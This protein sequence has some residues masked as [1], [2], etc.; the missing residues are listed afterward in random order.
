MEAKLDIEKDNHLRIKRI[1][2]G[3]LAA[4]ERFPYLAYVKHG[5]KHCGGTILSKNHVLTAAHCVCETTRLTYVHTG[6]E[7]KNDHG[8]WT[9]VSRV[10]CHENYSKT[11]VRENDVA[12]LVLGTNFSLKF[13]DKTRSIPMADHEPKAED[14]GYVCGWG[15][16]DSTKNFPQRMR[17]AAIDVAEDWRCENHFVQYKT[18]GTFCA[19][20]RD[21]RNACFGDSG[22]PFIV[23]KHLAGVISQGRDCNKSYTLFASVPYYRKWIEN[24]MSKPVPE[25][26]ESSVW[27]QFW[28]LLKG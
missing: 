23:R 3:S 16:L 25:G 5:S 18:A 7:K 22:G 19:G 14:W 8:T 10:I 20:T 1:I 15:D 11:K 26:K 24:K 4:I 21:G 13:D 9:E 12:I 2:E 6:S 28:D 17:I 27:E